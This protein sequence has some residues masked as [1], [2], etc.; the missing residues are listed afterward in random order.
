MRFNELIKSANDYVNV[1]RSAITALDS[2]IWK[3]FIGVCYLFI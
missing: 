2:D 3:E 1:V